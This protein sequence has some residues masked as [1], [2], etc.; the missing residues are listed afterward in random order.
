MSDDGAAERFYT[1]VLRIYPGWYREERGDEILGVLMEGDAK[2]SVG[3][4]ASLVRHGLALRMFGPN[5]RGVWRDPLAAAAVLVAAVAG[6]L[7]LVTALDSAL[8]AY[9]IAHHPDPGSVPY[10][11]PLWGAC[12]CSAAAL[13][14]VLLRQGWAALVAAWAAVVL[15]VLVAAGVFGLRGSV[16]WPYLSFA[17]QFEV[18]VHVVPTLA[19]AVLLSRPS[20]V[21]DGLAL[22]GRGPLLVIALLVVVPPYVGFDS[23]LWPYVIGLGGALVVLGRRGL[24]LRGGLAVLL[25]FAWLVTVPLADGFGAVLPHSRVL[26]SVVLGLLPLVVAPLL[27]LAIR[28]VEAGGFLRR[29]ARADDQDVAGSQ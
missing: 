24:A 13:V 3:E 28:N 6:G 2:P 1:A 16:G 14:L 12:A 23:E 26:L 21:A 15:Q 10:V 4:T 19:V 7:G 22:V 17:G 11:D 18:A 27:L 29:R 9:L 8:A 5:R 20:R 25:G